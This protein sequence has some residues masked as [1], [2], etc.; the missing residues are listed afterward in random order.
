MNRLCDGIET[1][2]EEVVQLEAKIQFALSTVPRMAQYTLPYVASVIGVLDS[3][4]GELVGSALRCTLGGRRAIVTALHVIE[5]ARGNR[6]E[7]V[8]LSA[9]YGVPPFQVQGKLFFDRAA[10][11]AIYFLPED[12]PQQRRLAFWPENRIDGNGER[13]ATDYLFVHGFPGERS[14]PSQLLAG[15]VSRSLPYGVMQRVEDLPGDLQPFQFAMDFDPLG[16][17][18]EPGQLSDRLPDPHGLSGCPVWRIGASGRSARDWTPDWSLLV[19]IVTE[20]RTDA[21][22]LVAT[23]FARVLDLAQSAKS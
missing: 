18:V 2:A 7:S 15:V 4:R 20:W 5:Q 9:G 21:E 22:I 3:Q 12:N 14:Y 19:G 6:Y 13:L 16:I 17:R 10:D 8:A 1:G 23:R 11:L